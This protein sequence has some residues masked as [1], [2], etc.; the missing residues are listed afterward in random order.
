MKKIITSLFEDVD[1]GRAR[2][3][4]SAEERRW[5]R[6]TISDHDHYR[7]NNDVPR[8]ELPLKPAAVLVPLVDRT[9]GL[10]VLLT[11][12]ASTL[13]THSG[14]VAF[15]GGRCDET[16]AHA[17]ETALREAQEEVALDPSLVNVVG[18]MED[19]ETVTGYT[20]A[21][22]VGFVQPTFDLHPEDGEVEDIFEVSLDFILDEKNQTIESRVWQGKER[23]FY[24]FPHESHYIWGATAAMLVRLSQMINAVKG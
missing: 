22:V 1:P 18:A 21:P 4:R 6:P 11:K 15:P 2:A 9:E 10:S 13:K 16:D 3:L 17:I 20:V 12:R 8:A 24:V 23:H 14:Q 7:P 5:Q 19:Y